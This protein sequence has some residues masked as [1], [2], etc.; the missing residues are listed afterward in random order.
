MARGVFVVGTDT[1]VGKTTVSLA[2]VHAFTSAGRRLA[3]MKPCETGNG[4][5]AARLLAATGRRLDAQ[6]VNPYRFPLPAAPEIAARRA[7][8][9][10]ELGVIHQAYEAL[11]RDADLTLVEG[12]GGLLVPLA[13]GLTIADLI[14]RLDLPV[15]IVART[16]LGTINHTLLTAEVA[17]RRGLRVLGVI[18]SELRRAPRSSSGGTGGPFDDETVA[19]IARFG[20][21]PSFGV[22]PWLSPALRS[23]GPRL[24]AL[25]RAHLRIDELLEALYSS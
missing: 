1:G 23:D 3:V 5:D 8:L 19:T 15:L 4:D 11:S 6:L 12:A 20:E 10:I 21:L 25:A 16:Q 9:R 24:A 13:D 14:L 7:G 17:R 2:L 22:L 18:F